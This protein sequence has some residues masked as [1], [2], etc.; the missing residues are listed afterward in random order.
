MN[1]T[2]DKVAPERHKFYI[3]YWC[4]VATYPGVLG[5][6]EGANLGGRVKIPREVSAVYADPDKITIRDDLPRAWNP[7]GTP[8]GRCES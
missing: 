8:A 2:L 7:D 3:G 1:V 5:V 6:Y 4:E